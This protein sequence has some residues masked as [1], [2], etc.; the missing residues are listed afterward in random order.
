MELLDILN[1]IFGITFI[2]ISF[3]LGI[4][5]TLKYRKNKNP[6]FILMGI[7]LLLLTAGWYGT[8][9]SFLVALIFQNQG[10]S[11]EVIL[12]V[13]FI[14]FPISLIT[15]MFFYS[16]VILLKYRKKY[17]LG[18]IIG[19]VIFFYIIFFSIVFT[20]ADFV[21]IKL[22]PVDTSGKNWI[23]NSFIVVYVLLFFI[24]GLKFSIDTMKLD[25]FEMQLRGKFLLVA[26][27]SFTIAGLLDSVLPNSTFTLILRIILIS[28]IIEFYLGFVLPKWI[29]RRVKK[30]NNS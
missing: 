6:H 4:F 1:G 15:W 25:D 20:N 30:P 10:L 13:N 27:P 21:A 12:L 3:V 22:S 16:D 28:S 8:S 19:Y 7:T 17:I 5:V 2:L 26:F 23:L 18:A 9:L 29:K 14:P 24:T 11:I